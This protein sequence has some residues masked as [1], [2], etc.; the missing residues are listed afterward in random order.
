[1]ARWFQRLDSIGRH[2]TAASRLIGMQTPPLDA[3]WEAMRTI[4]GAFLIVLCLGACG[5]PNAATPG[6]TATS[7]GVATLAP[8]LAPTA[9]AASPSIEPSPAATELVRGQEFLPGRYTRAAF[10]PRITFEVGADWTAVQAF[11]GFFDIQQDAGSPDVI[12]VQFARPDGFYGAGGALVE[13]TTPAEA[14]ATI[15]AN[16][17]V[18]VL[19]SSTS[20]MSGLDGFVV[21][22]ENPAT[23][24]GPAQILDVP[25]GPL[26]IDPSRRLWIAVFD[27]PDGLLAILVGGSVAR[28]EE[29]LAAAE[30]VLETVT[31]GG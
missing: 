1:M 7:T 8:T 14:A 25:L 20:R 30:P 29:A 16:A 9:S 6:A 27:T 5:E 11:E 21:E 15:A 4:L 18:T 19:E 22:V 28:W 24:G 26:S 17:A 12:A 2:R 3:R 23:A 31:I 10:E 13:A